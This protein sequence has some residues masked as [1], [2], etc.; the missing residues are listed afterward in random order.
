[1]VSPEPG[2]RMLG[3]E[4]GVVERVGVEPSPPRSPTFTCEEATR[5]RAGLVECTED[6]ADAA[7]VDFQGL[8]AE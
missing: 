4:R 2:T 8:P 5:G 7:G 6:M 3:P 1:M